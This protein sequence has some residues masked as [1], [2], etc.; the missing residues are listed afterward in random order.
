[1]RGN[2]FVRDDGEREREEGERQKRERGRER[3][4]RS[5]KE[6]DILYVRETWGKERERESRGG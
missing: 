4:E 2:V 3:R 5:N 6:R 1:M